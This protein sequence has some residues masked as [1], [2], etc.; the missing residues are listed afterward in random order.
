MASGCQASETRYQTAPAG[1]VAAIAQELDTVP[2]TSTPT[3]QHSRRVV[4]D[5]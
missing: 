1:G 2:P 3:L 5:G 4:L